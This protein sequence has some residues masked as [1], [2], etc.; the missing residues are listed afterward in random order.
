M[1]IL[2]TAAVA[3]CLGSASTAVATESFDVNIYQPVFQRNEL[4]ANA[5]VARHN[6]PRTMPSTIQPFTAEEDA[7]FRRMSRPE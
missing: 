7:L 4:S 3:A 5:W 6:T 1:K 2:V